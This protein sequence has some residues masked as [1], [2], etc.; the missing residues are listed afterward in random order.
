M[1]YTLDSTI[2]NTQWITGHFHLISQ[3][4][5]SSCFAIAYELWPHHRSPVALRQARL[6]QLWLWFIGMLVVTLPWHVVGLMGQP[7]R[8]AYYDW[9]DRDRGPGSVGERFCVGDSFCCC[10]RFC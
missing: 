7:R 9:S 4:R 5:S 1:S 2:H 6:L 3:A 10:Q 8:M